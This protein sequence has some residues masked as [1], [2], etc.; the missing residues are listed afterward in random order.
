MGED[1][2][3]LDRAL[4]LAPPAEPGVALAARVMADFDAVAARRRLGPSG[5]AGGI[6]VKVCSALW[7]GAPAWQPATALALSLALGIAAGIFAPVSEASAENGEQAAAVA[8]DQ[9]PA[10]EIGETS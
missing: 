9:P 10:F 5:F 1:E 8:L 2:A 6:V 4:R 3:W 7:P